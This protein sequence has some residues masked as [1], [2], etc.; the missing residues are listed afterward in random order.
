MTCIGSQ[1]ADRRLNWRH[2]GI[3]YRSPRISHRVIPALWG[4]T[5]SLSIALAEVIGSDAL[6][7]G[8]GNWES[9]E[10]KAFWSTATVETIAPCLADPELS[11]TGGGD[12]SKPLIMAARYN[13]DPA[14]VEA[15]IAAGARMGPEEP[16][17]GK[18]DIA[19][20][21]AARHNSNSAIVG[22]LLEHGI[23]FLNSQDA[24]G[25]APLHYAAA[26]GNVAA[27]EA[28]IAAGADVNLGERWF[29]ATPLQYAAERDD[30]AEMIALF[31]SAGVD[32][33]KADCNGD[34]PLHRGA[35]WSKTTTT[36]EALLHAGADVNA[37]NERR[38]RVP[39]RA[40]GGP[41]L[42]ATPL[43]VAARHNESV[44]VVKALIAA[45]AEP[46]LAGGNLLLTPLQEAAAHNRNPAVVRALLDAGANVNRR[47]LPAGKGDSETFPS[48]RYV[49][50]SGHIDNDM[51]PLHLATMDNSDSGVVDA[52]LSSGADVEAK[53]A[54][55]RTPLHL[56]AKAAS[57]SG[58]VDA[59]LSS[60]VDVEAKDSWG[61]TPLHYA[62]EANDNPNVVAALVREGADV[63]SRS[64]DYPAA[65]L[66]H[67][68]ARYGKDP[69]TISRF[70]AAGADVN[71]MD[72]AEATPLHYAATY[73]DNPNI[74]AA[75]VEAGADVNARMRNRYDLE[76]GLGIGE[77]PIHRAVRY[78]PAAS[79]TKALLDAGANP[80]AIDEHGDT[81]LDLVRYSSRDVRVLLEAWEREHPLDNSDVL[82]AGT[83]VFIPG[84]VLDEFERVRHKWGQALTY[85]MANY[86]VTAPSAWD[87][88]KD[89]SYIPLARHDGALEK[90]I[91][92][93]VTNIRSIDIGNKNAFVIERETVALE[94]TDGI[95]RHMNINQHRE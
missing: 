49:G 11:E 94:V 50:R 20:H 3:R 9:D 36:L 58:V 21:E 89:T 33:N 43:H 23:G 28:L 73:N 2:V 83:L 31:V 12:A 60:G 46:N 71:V 72:G 38:G 87:E 57:D 19:L 7:S 86:F 29:N 44:A 54:R 13:S 27:A 93:D 32:V 25:G 61:R 45:G 14:V 10:A 69:S 95:R 74:V 91:M 78:N 76:K 65:T 52:L 84:W 51:T 1:G 75:L 63:N 79:V 56:A 47:V 26:S 64:K 35:K 40:I 24:G 59:L 62:L 55:G 53:D 4:L 16:E 85:L 66:L 17:R 88:R 82:P 80:R 41:P 77:T 22:V 30:N 68:V 37:R 18:F 67:K 92:V 8:C 70:I 39:C 42:G 5:L 15:L 6:A 48:G 34:T 81:P 90:T